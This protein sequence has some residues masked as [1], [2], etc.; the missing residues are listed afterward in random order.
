VS[1]EKPYIETPVTTIKVEYNPKYGDERLCIC[2]HFYYRHFDSYDDMSP[3][4]CKYCF[5]SVFKES[6]ASTLREILIEQTN[7]IV[8][9]DHQL[10]IEVAMKAT[11]RELVEKCLGAIHFGT[12]R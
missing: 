9:Q 1:E 3:V 10:D 7:F 12:K 5:C 4:G 11:D 8:D 2:G 6:K